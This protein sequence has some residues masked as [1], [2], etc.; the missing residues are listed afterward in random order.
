MTNYDKLMYKTLFSKTKQNML[1][2]FKNKNIFFYPEHQHQIST[3]N[4]E[5]GRIKLRI[6]EWVGSK[7]IASQEKLKIV[8]WKELKTAVNVW[9]ILCQHSVILKVKDWF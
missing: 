3:S 8:S 2:S 1:N 4:T 9:R 7:I 6:K 5:N